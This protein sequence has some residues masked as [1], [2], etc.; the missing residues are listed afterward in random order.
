[1]HQPTIYAMTCLLAGCTTNA[2]IDNSMTSSIGQDSFAIA[3]RYG[4]PISYQHQ[5][6]Q[7]QLNY[8]SEAVGCRVIFLIDEHHR[9]AGWAST[10]TKC[11]APPSQPD[12]P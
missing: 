3:A 2:K 10:G 4:T 9:V 12:A 11:S 5:S 7:L 8:G 6:D 1:M